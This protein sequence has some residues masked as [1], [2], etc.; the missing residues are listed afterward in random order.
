MSYSIEF[1]IKVEGLENV[2]VNVGDCTAN[3]TWNLRDMIIK[4]T[5]LEWKNEENNGLCKDVIPHIVDGLAELIKYP[6]KYK[7]YE[8]PN[9][10]GTIE[11]CKRFFIQIINDWSEFCND[12]LTSD[13]ANITYFWII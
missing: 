3:T 5:N 11:D 1:K 13:L 7:Q 12:S 4:S 10:W 2:Y 8:S 6:E 9:G